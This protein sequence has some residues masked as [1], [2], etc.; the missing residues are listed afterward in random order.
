MRYVHDIARR[1]SRQIHVGR[2]AVGGDAP[3]SVQTMTSTDTE[4]VD[5]TVAQIKACMSAGADIVRVSVPTL[6]AAKAFGF[7]MGPFAV[8]DMSGLDIAWA[9]R[10]RQAAT[11]DP[12]ARYV[13]IPDRLCEA[14]RLGRKTGKGWYDHS[15][16]KP[17][18]DPE[19]A[20]LIA[21]ARADAG[22]SPR[23]YDAETIQRQ[24][25]AAIVNEAA[26][27]LDEGIAQRA[28]DIDVVLTNGYG[29]PRWRGGPLYWAA[30]HDRA[31]LEADLADLAQAMGHGFRAG[32]VA[33]TLDQI[34]IPTE[35]Q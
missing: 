18:P 10:K 31:A 35:G 30:R 4:D 13:T 32:P 23:S 17:V 28:S 25:L 21:A 22:I 3:V 24:L 19:V 7:A 14:G 1:K 9:M 20:A 34:D 5:A 29:F 15:G 11:R 2:V 26:C 8:S 12:K 27:L 33:R 16:G 6:A